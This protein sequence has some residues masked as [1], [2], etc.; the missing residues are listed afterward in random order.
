M[1]TQSSSIAKPDF[2]DWLSPMLVKEL[3]QGLRSRVFLALFIALQ[4]AMIFPAV[5]GLLDAASGEQNESAT[6]FFWLFVTVPLM[7]AMPASGLSTIGVEK[8]SNTLEPIFLTR[9]TARRILLGK[10]VAIVGQTLLVVAAILP[11]SVLRYY[12]GNVNLVSELE[13][14]GVLF[15]VSALLTAVAVGLSPMVGRLG[16]I[17]FPIIGVI[18]LF[19]GAQILF[20]PWS[21]FGVMRGGGPGP[22]WPTYLALALLG[23]L[24][25]ALMLEAG[26]GKI[27]PAAE[28]HATPKR[29]LA[30]AI[31][32]VAL[33]Y[34]DWPGDHE[35]VWGPVIFV[36]VVASIGALCEPIP[37]IVRIYQPFL[38][39][40]FPGRAL[41]RFFYPGWPAGFLFAL[42]VCGLTIAHLH[43]RIAGALPARLDLQELTCLRIN[44][45]ASIG[46]LLLP[47]ALY[48][49]AGLKKTPAVAFYFGIQGIFALVSLV[50]SLHF[51]ATEKPTGFEAFVAC[52]PTCALCYSGLIPSWTLSQQEAILI[53]NSV[54][55]AAVL[56]IL[57]VKSWPAW[58]AI[59][60]L[61][62]IAARIPV[63]AASPDVVRPLATD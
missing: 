33:F 35:W 19:I 60:K 2:P 59:A 28:N 58:R 40:G 31:V 24:L 25:A 10:W 49:L 4:V 14:L 29:W 43:Q 8:Q 9:L 34:S 53:G 32:G 42:A 38:R 37:Q 5:F 55:T 39:W 36:V 1:S 63:A 15:A 20:Q 45:A 11:Y 52:F 56:L 48:R 54:V 7:I 47:M 13:V 22:L 21:M 44:E 6:V 23:A 57:A 12:L 62:K 3:R 17:L 18:A 27:A 51:G 16:R 50:G 26:A 46:A 30:L 41:G 61:E